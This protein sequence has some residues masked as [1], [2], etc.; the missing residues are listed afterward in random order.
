MKLYRGNIG[1]FTGGIFASWFVTGVKG[2]VAF[3]TGFVEMPCSPWSLFYRIIS[4][5][6]GRTYLGAAVDQETSAAS[7]DFGEVFFNFMLVV[8][9]HLGSEGNDQPLFFGEAPAFLRTNGNPVVDAA[10]RWLIERLP[11]LLRTEWE[12]RALNWTHPLD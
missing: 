9:N 7:G 12:P 6:G 8:N 2:P 4:P 11:N 10:M 5:F 3:A 1:D